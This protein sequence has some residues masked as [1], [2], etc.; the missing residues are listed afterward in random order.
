MIDTPYPYFTQANTLG[1]SDN[2]L[3]D[4]NY[5]LYVPPFYTEYP[6]KDMLLVVESRLAILQE[7]RKTQKRKKAH[8]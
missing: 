4:M 8:S 2:E 3:K 7:A 6:E 5:Y 1:F